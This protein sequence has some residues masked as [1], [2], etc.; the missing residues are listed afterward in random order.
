[1]RT[2]RSNLVVP[3]SGQSVPVS[4][5]QGHSRGQFSVHPLTATQTYTAHTGSASAST[6]G[7]LPCTLTFMSL[8]C[9]K[10]SLLRLKLVFGQ[11]SLAPKVGQSFQL[12]GHTR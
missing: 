8:P 10:S 6:T 1:V 7:F 12:R 3:Q 5:Y 4:R 11:G 9:D 2:V